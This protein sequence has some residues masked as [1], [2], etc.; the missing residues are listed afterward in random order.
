MVK[1]VYIPK[2]ASKRVGGS[3]PLR[4]LWYSSM[5]FAKTSTDELNQRELRERAVA[6]ALAKEEQATA[7]L[8]ALRE[9]RNSIK[10]SIKELDRTPSTLVQTRVHR[11]QE[12]LNSLPNQGKV[13]QLDEELEEFISDNM[14]M[15]NY[16]LSNRAWV[17]NTEILGGL[18]GD[19]DAVEPK[20]IKSTAL[21]AYSA[22]FPNLKPTPDHKPYSF[23]E[24]Y[25]R[26]LNHAR[27]SGNLGSF[28]SNVYRPRNEILK[29]LKE[30][31]V[32]MSSLLAAGCHLGHSK[33]AWRPSTQ[34][35]IFGEYDNIH[36]IDL[37]ETIIQLKRACKVVKGVASK[38]GLILYVGT[39]KSGEQHRALEEGAKRSK[40]YYVSKRWIP[41]TITN[42]TEVTKQVGSN[43][44]TEIDMQDIPT[45]RKLSE[46][47]SEKLIKP[48]LVVILNPVENRNCIDE[49]I[50]LRI[51][52]I[53][54]CD[55]NMEPSLLT[56]PIPCNDDSMRVSSLMMG[57]ISNSAREGVSIRYEAFNDL[58]SNRTARK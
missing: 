44:R 36:L 3:L 8:K 49:C 30:N 29:P 15:P 52:T 31:E 9:L 22:Q 45:K 26:Q 16:E 51:P 6:E 35:F 4:G 21:S 58:T 19:G 24:L 13:K 1:T 46:E 47:E 39:S 43:D 7:K 53:G 23:Q 12:E 25:L 48:D 2:K 5:S 10:D 55:T 33:A 34:P 37:N 17:N 18:N 14:K 42:F 20:K 54:L 27:Q 40:G 32:S 11:L 28:L 38:G 56:Y 50:K 41:G 57:V